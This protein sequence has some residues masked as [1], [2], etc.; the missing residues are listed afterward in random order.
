MA[1]FAFVFVLMLARSRVIKIKGYWKG[2]VDANAKP[3]AITGIYLDLDLDL[4]VHVYIY[5]YTY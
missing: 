5:I 1:M 4:H 3:D 2:E